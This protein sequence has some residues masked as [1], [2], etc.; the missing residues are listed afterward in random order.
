MK[1]ICMQLKVCEGCGALWLRALNDG[2]YCGRCAV[3][4]ADFPPPR[5]RS[6]RGRRPKSAPAVIATPV[7]AP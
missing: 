5:G 1:H 7:G 6:R 2:V 3:V 4:L